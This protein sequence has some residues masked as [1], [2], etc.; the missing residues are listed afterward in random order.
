MRSEKIKIK[1][2]INPKFWQA[3]CSSFIFSRTSSRNLSKFRVDQCFLLPSLTLSSA[4][5]FLP[6]ACRRTRTRT[7]V[8]TAVAILSTV[9]RASERARSESVQ[10]LLTPPK[11]VRR[12][13][14]D[15]KREIV[16]AHPSTDHHSSPSVL[17][18]FSLSRSRSPSLRGGNSRPSTDTELAGRQKREESIA[19]E[20]KKGKFR[21]V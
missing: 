20:Q 5:V 11:N 15:V 6:G 19:R 12:F 21:A 3:P 9:K 7:C 10:E 13:K 16:H 18:S 17:L 4:I 8:H 2:K 14:D 1:I